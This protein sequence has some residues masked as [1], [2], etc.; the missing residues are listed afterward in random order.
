MQATICCCTK[1]NILNPRSL[2]QGETS[3][4][5]NDGTKPNERLIFTSD[6]IN[7]L[8]YGPRRCRNSYICQKHA[9]SVLVGAT[10]PRSLQQ[11]FRVEAIAI[12]LD[13]SNT[14][15]FAQALKAMET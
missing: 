10:C 8:I 15:F 2:R 6:L 4:V 14:L 12:S 13:K 11:V 9:Q 1:E 5:P 3:A 7:E